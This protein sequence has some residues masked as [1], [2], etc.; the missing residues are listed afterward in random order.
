M[1]KTV[2]CAA[3]AAA[4][5]S[6][7]GGS[8]ESRPGPGDEFTVELSMDE[9][10]SEISTYRV[11]GLSK[12]GQLVTTSD[13]LAS[14]GLIPIKVSSINPNKQTA[15][16]LPDMAALQAFLSEFWAELGKRKGIVDPSELA[17][18][19]YDMD[20]SLVSVYTDYRNSGLTMSEFVD[21]YE[22][23]DAHPELDNTGNG[24]AELSQFFNNFQITPKQMLEALQAHGSNW[25]QFLVLMASRQDDFNSLYEQYGKSG[26]N[27]SSFVQAYLQPQ[28]KTLKNAATVIAV[29]KFAWDVIKDNRPQTEA[30]GAFTR[31]LSGSDDRYDQYQLAKRSASKVVH[32]KTKGL[33]PV[34]Q[35]EVKFALSGYYDAKHPSI[36]GHWLPLINM[37]V[38]E[39]YA[40]I[41][42]KVNA[43]ASVTQPVNVGTVTTPVPEMP[44]FMQVTTSGVFQNFTQK[45]E[46]RA[47]GKN[48]FSYIGE[49]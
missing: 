44:V 14:D 21:F 5:L 25:N 6:A 16:D 13:N 39:M 35:T 31:A 41:S 49:K 43:K 48:G 8:D 30:Q 37:D 46:F 45:Y 36:G 19:V 40:I 23:L 42:W 12:T 24:E 47:N 33:I 11:Y 20:I 28:N 1:K 4:F 29:S 22:A 27:I 7:C 9:A 38:K 32:I 2:L 18:E 26:T 3:L 34:T 15:K 10:L 17:Q